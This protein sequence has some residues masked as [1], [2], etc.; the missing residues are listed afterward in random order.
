MTKITENAEGKSGHSKSITF[1]Q[2]LHPKT[3]SI[4]S[5]VYISPIYFLFIFGS[6]WQLPSRR[7]HNRPVTKADVIIYII[8]RTLHLA[9]V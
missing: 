3:R 9:A 7:I 1:E 5:G 4:F 6:K 8:S 2:T